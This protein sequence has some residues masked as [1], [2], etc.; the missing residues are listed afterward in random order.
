MLRNRM[1]NTT[2]KKLKKYEMY[3]FSYISIIETTVMMEDWDSI[4]KF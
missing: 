4:R 3:I 1:T 2:K